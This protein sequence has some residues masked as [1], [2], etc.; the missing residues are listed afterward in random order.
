MNISK[1]LRAAAKRLLANLLPADM[2]GYSP[3]VEL[4]HADLS[5]L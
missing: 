1:F 5:S 4:K 3:T 2:T